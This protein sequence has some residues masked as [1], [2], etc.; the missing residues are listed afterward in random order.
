MANEWRCIRGTV[1]TPTYLQVTHQSLVNIGA[2]REDGKNNSAVIPNLHHLHSP[3]RRTG[4]G[5]YA[6]CAEPFPKGAVADTSKRLQTAG[7]VM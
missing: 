4:A 5:A 7:S 1:A 6:L 3:E 2:Y